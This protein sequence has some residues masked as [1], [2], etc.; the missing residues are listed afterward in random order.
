MSTEPL[1]I[2]I[3]AAAECIGVCP[4]TVREMIADK[5]LC[6]SR[7][8]GRAG[9]RGRIVIP[10]ASLVKLLDDTRVQS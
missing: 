10:I 5:R 7:L 2:S 8:V 4:R 3:D 9:K 6:A 1:A